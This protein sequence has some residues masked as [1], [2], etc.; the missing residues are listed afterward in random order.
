[1]KLIIA[2]VHDEDNRKVMDALN[3]NGFMVTKLC[4]SGGFLKAG[5]TT[6]LTGVD[7]NKVQEAVDIIGKTSKVRKQMMNSMPYSTAGLPIMAE[8]VEVTV[9]GA[10]IFITDVERFE[11][12]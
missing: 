9:G 10:T 7:E 8:P 3:E 5:N 2:I 6:L 11:K 12:V 4:S 1:M